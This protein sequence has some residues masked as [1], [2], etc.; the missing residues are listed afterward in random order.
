MPRMSGPELAARLA[1]LHREAKVLYMS[2]HTDNAIAHHGV[3][4]PGT[5]FLQKPFVPEILIKKIREVLDEL[6]VS[7]GASSYVK[8]EGCPGNR[9]AILPV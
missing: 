4:D 9:G 6:V 8:A 7:G 2:G 1:P 3:L 5:H